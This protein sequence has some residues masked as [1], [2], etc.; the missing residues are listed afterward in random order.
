MAGSA[1]LEY[2]DGPLTDW[3]LSWDPAFFVAGDPESYTLEDPCA[4]SQ[5]RTPDP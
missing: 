3:G 1:N 4:R 2:E 5:T